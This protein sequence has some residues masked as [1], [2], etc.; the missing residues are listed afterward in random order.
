MIIYHSMIAWIVVM[1]G[2]YTFAKQTDVIRGEKNDEVPLIFAVV[3][4]GYIVFWSGMRSGVA[5][6][7]V[8]IDMF[9]ALEENIF[10]IPQYW[11]NDAKGPGF[12]TLGVLFK[13]LISD[14]YHMWFTFIATVSGVGIMYTLKKHSVN[15]FYSAFLFIVT[16]NFY[17]LLNG[18]RQFLVAAVLFGL[19]DWVIQR[20]TVPFMIA[21][22]LLST[23][24][25][26]VL[27]MIPIYF[28]VTGRPFGGK[29]I[30]FSVILIGCIVFLEPF[31]EILNTALAET[32]YS[33]AVEQ[34][35]QDD[36]VNPI[37]VLVMAI[38]SVIALMGRK[39]LEQL[40][41]TYIN[42][43]V[44]MSFVSAGLYFIGMFTS[45]ILVG[46]LPIYF[47]LYNMI[48]LP[49]LIENIFNYRSS[50]FIYILC[51]IGYLGFYILQSGPLYYISEITGLLN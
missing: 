41:N 18:I 48:L 42:V 16:L 49:F 34:F 9:E 8:Y 1:A 28:I 21:I 30:F 24:H 10:N 45:G 6:T 37:R 43:C 32:N 13:S 44:N 2:L 47:E 7:A 17:W 26:T 46:R 38:P 4:F 50:K 35:A 33:G 25:S 23:I 40:G 20:K 11:F 5:D 15:F 3:T 29:I 12:R 51:T 19:S 31:T 36:G 14:N 22:L 39:Q 27:I